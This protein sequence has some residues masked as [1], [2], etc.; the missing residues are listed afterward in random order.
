MD[1]KNSQPLYFVKIIFPA[2]K[3]RYKMSS[4]DK[5]D[6]LKSIGD[7]K[8]VLMMFNDSG[9]DEK[10]R[11]MTPRDRHEFIDWMFD[12]FNSFDMSKTRWNLAKEIVEKFRGFKNLQ[13]SVDWVNVLLKMKICKYEDGTYGFKADC[14]F[15]VD[16]VCQ[17]PSIIRYQ[18]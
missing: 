1:L 3:K 18:K 11:R 8:K 10:P 12:N 16:D 14:P 5:P 9:K 2:S 13:L 17:T 6:E 15:T 4:E 7:E